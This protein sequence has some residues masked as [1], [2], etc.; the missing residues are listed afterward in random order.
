M[1]FESLES[2]LG[3]IKLLTEQHVVEIIVKVKGKILTFYLLSGMSYV[4]ILFMCY[5]AWYAMLLD[6]SSHD[7][8]VSSASGRVAG[9]VGQRPVRMPEFLTEVPGSG[10]NS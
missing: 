8:I 3:R 10:S 2:K 7:Q 1:F 9:V 5:Y 6:R 4:C